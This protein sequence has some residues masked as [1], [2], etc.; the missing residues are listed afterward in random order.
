MKL[1]WKLLGLVPKGSSCVCPKWNSGYEAL[2]YLGAGGSQLIR[3][4]SIQIPG[5]FEKK[6]IMENVFRTFPC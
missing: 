5:L 1:L 2:G 3:T 6:K 4:R